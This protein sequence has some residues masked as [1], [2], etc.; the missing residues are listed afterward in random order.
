M[1]EQAE[2]VLRAV[3]EVEDR[4]DKYF[5][6]TVYVSLL[7]G[8]HENVIK[9]WRMDD[10]RSFGKLRTMTAAQL[11][12]LMEQMI[13]M[14]FLAEDRDGQYTILTLGPS[15]PEVLDGSRRVVIRQKLQI[16][17]PEPEKA[18]VNVPLLAALKALRNRLAQ[19]ARVPAYMVFS[20][21]TLEDM[22]RL[23]P[24]SMTALK[25]VSGV[26]EKKALLYGSQFLE[27]IRGYL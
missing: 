3:R 13:V 17:P 26:G 19:E 6:I 27:V 10:L 25:R 9:A 5:G 18:P 11:R 21:A 1:T 15:A 12:T 23:M 22:A 8:S 4:Y 7:H 14:G 16:A 2:T 24:D 20:N